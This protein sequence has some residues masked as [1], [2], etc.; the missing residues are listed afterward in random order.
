MATDLAH[1]LVNADES[2]YHWQDISSLFTSDMQVNFASPR[3]FATS[4][5]CVEAVIQS[6]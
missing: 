1:R 2:M 3:A 5:Q 4:A 6:G